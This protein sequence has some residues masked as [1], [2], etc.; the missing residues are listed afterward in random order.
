VIVDEKG[1]LMRMKL[2]KGNVDDR[3]VVPDMAEG[4]WGLLLGDKDTVLN[5][6][7]FLN[8]F[9]YCYRQ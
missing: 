4:L 8:I 3:A 5:V 2:T 7:S 9:C 6:N 1:N